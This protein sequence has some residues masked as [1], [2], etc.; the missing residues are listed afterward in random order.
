MP[1]YE[2]YLLG[3]YTIYSLIQISYWN[4]YNELKKKIM[5][6]KF[7]FT[8]SWENKYWGYMNKKTQTK[9]HTDLLLT[10]LF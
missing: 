1:A 4:L 2:Q 7:Q 5:M 9:D 10:A 8:I 6:M 3:T